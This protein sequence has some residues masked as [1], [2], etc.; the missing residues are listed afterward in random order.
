MIFISLASAGLPG[1]NGF[2]GEVL[3]LIGM[4]K[5]H[6][7]YAVLGAVGIVLGAW[8]LLTMIQRVFFGPVREPGHGSVG[9]LNGR[10]A[11]ALVPLAALCLI[12]GV[13][14]RPFTDAFRADV[15]AVV[16]PYRYPERLQEPAPREDAS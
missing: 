5:V 12:I 13:Y 3:C 15:E 2:V 4:F 10:E 8:Y 7:A 11:L 1:L 9:D 6:P 14:P 16:A